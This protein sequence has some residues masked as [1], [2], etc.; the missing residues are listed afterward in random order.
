[1]TIEEM[2]ENLTKQMETLKTDLLSLEKDFNLK[3]EQFLR[4]QGALE[5]LNAVDKLEASESKE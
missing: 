1:M 2:K 4:M 5:A 3:K